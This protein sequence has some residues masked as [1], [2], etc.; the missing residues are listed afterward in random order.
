MLKFLINFFRA[1]TQLQFE[2]VFLKKQLE[3]LN[4]SNKKLQ[5]LNRDRLFFTVMKRIFGNWKESL[6]IIKPETV[7]NWHRKGF[8]L[9]WGWKSR[10]T[11]GRPKISKEQIDLIKQMAKDNPLWGI[12][13]IHGEIMKL[14]FDIS[15]ST[16]MRYVTKKNGRTSGQRWKI[17]LKNHSAEIVSIDFLTVPTYNFKLMYVLIFLSHERRRIIHFNVSSHP[18]SEWSTQQLKNALYDSDSPKFLIRDRDT[19]FGSL[20]SQTVSDCGIREIVTAYR[21]PWQNGYCERVIGS[22]RREFL[23]HVI[24]INENHL[25]KLLK[26][27][28]HYYNYQRTHLGLEKDSPESRPVQVIGKIEKMAVANGLHN[29]YYRK[30]A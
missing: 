21:S 6:V 5:I 29:Y 25:R 11:R 23:D 14:G 18:T 8:K 24:V 3:I 30:A 20:F 10:H 12:P 15:E 13:R 26:E 28:F 1:R 19:K 17:F 7:I 4:R 9:Y 16:V 2:I 22:I 27:Y